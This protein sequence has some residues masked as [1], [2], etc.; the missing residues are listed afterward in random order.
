MISTEAERQFY[1]ARM[2]VQLWYA[3]E[4]LPG[5]A[6]TPPLDFTEPEVPES[7][8]APAS[9]AREISARPSAGGGSAQGNVRE[10]LKSIGGEKE[11]REGQERQAKAD[12]APESTGPVV[13]GAEPPA[14]DRLTSAPAEPVDTTAS[15]DQ[16]RALAG[17]E[18]VALD[19]GL[20]QGER[21][22]LASTLSADVSLDLQNQLASNIL[23][24]MGDAALQQRHFVWPVFNNPRVMKNAGR[25]LSTLVQGL[26][27]TFIGSRQFIVL[28]AL[29]GTEQ[30]HAALTDQLSSSAVVCP[31]S[32]AALAA[33]PA[34]K[35][36]LWRRLQE[37]V[38]GVL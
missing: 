22:C 26:S 15:E 18:Q 23:K 4:P 13:S 7:A 3:R 31:D 35:R 32:L 12:T 20:W 29:A 8:P 11:S 25:D 2:G 30:A 34:K 33:D 16:S 14:S 10:L 19:L 17:L 38:L 28:G 37:H 1:L 36:E 6:P 21:I 5:G 27:E 24:A 9:P